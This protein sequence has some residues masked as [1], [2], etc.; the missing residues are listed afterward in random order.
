MKLALPLC[1]ALGI[2]AA[3]A[4]SVRA[5]DS[6]SVESRVARLE[7]QLDRLTA[8]VTRQ[9]TELRDLKKRLSEPAFVVR[10]APAPAA[11]VIPEPPIEPAPEP[12]PPLS[13]PVPDSAAAIVDAEI[14]RLGLPTLERPMTPPTVAPNEAARKALGDHE[15]HARAA[16][17]LLA[18][19][20]ASYAEILGGKAS[21]DQ[22]ATLSHRISTWIDEYRRQVA[23][24]NASL[25]RFY[26]SGGK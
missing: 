15:R 2:V 1:V 6:T 16:S 24:A 10:P 7:G 23:E 5:A 18:E 19:I 4:A 13:K 25:T 12:A 8:L 26:E 20:R 14:A 9:G 17:A 3:H 11:Q 22:V 21:A